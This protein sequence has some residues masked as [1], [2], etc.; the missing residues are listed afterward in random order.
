MNSSEAAHD[1]VL[2][3]TQ[4]LILQDGTY[5]RPEKI[6]QSW[7]LNG[8]K[9]VL[10]FPQCSFKEQF[11]EGA[12]IGAAVLMVWMLMFGFKA[13]KTMIFYG[14]GKDDN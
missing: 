4:P 1:Y 8:K 12:V 14:G 2:S 5:I 3:Q 7:F 6:G 10:S 9:V 11:Q 13:L